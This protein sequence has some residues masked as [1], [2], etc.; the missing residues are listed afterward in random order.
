[1]SLFGAAENTANRREKYDERLAEFDYMEHSKAAERIASDAERLKFWTNKKKELD[2]LAIEATGTGWGKDFF[3]IKKLKYINQ[4]VAEIEALKHIIQV[5]SEQPGQEN[6]DGRKKKGY[7]EM[8]IVAQQVLNSKRN[9]WLNEYVGDKK[10]FIENEI[11]PY[12]KKVFP[13]AEKYPSEPHLRNKV[14]NWNKPA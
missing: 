9:I 1:M 12:L 2:L 8:K 7:D 4:V 3:L 5:E 6:K 10:P 14:L 13:D 11:L